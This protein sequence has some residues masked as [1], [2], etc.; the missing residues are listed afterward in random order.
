MTKLKD[1]THLSLKNYSI[2]SLS[3]KSSALKQNPLK[4]ATRRENPVLLPHALS[5]PL[6]HTLSKSTG[7]RKS[8]S[9]DLEGIIFILAGF[10]GNGPNYLSLKSFEENYAQTID[11]LTTKG[12]APRAAYVFV[13]AWTSLGGSQFIN[14]SA[15]GKYEDYIVK[16]LLPAA[17]AALGK[18]LKVAIMG[19]SSGGYGAIHLATKFPKYF[20]YLLAVAPDAAFE[21]SLLKDIYKTANYLQHFKQ[22]D[23]M[24]KLKAGELKKLRDFH[25]ILNAVAMSACYSPRG[26][27]IDLPVDFY[28]GELKPHVWKKWQEKDPVHFLKKRLVATRKLKGVF[29]EVGK[30]DE[31]QLHFGARRIHQLWKKAKIP[32]HYNEFDGGHFDLS[33]RRD[34]MLTWLQKEWRP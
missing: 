31:F 2:K 3:I 28:T 20:P 7:S 30:K 27:N 6:P 19:G 4:D 32:H 25:S 12:L 18:N 1:F 22:E 13:D 29:L 8:Y 21:V 17:R 16:E 26:K 23:F 9:K 14:S 24:K 33:T 34:K 10:S 15:V 5:R 11:R